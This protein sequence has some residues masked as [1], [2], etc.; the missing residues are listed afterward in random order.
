MHLTITNSSNLFKSEGFATH[1]LYATKYHDNEKAASHACNSYD[2]R[3]PIIDFSKY[4][5][6]E[7]LIQ[8]DIVLWYNLGSESAT[9]RNPLS[10]RI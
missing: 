1:A 3:N 7:S 6:G 4:F 5:N 10:P 2:P 9:L 8:E